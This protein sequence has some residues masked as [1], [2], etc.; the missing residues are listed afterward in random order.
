MVVI[1]AVAIPMWRT[2]Q[3]RVQRGDAI[4]HYS[5]SRPRRIATSERTR[6]YADD[7]Q[8]PVAPPGG[9]GLTRRV[10]TQ[11]L[12]HRHRAGSGWIRVCGDGARYGIRAWRAR[13]SALRGHAPR[14]AWPP[15]GS[16]LGREDSTRGL[17]ESA[18]ARLSSFGGCPSCARNAR[19][20]EN[21]TCSSRPFSSS[22]AVPPHSRSRATTCCTSSS[23]AEAPAVT[24]TAFL[25]SN[26]S[27]FRKDASSIR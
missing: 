27:R 14:P 10:R 25:P 6:R 11:R 17:L 1:A 16:R 23:G 15:L 9:L 18:V 21:T 7:A 19:G 24:P 2:H 22:A 13:R 26:H 4:A 20:S 8:T 3:L 12:V 5:P